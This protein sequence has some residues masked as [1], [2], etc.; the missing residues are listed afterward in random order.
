MITDQKIERHR[1]VVERQL[2]VVERQF[3]VVERQTQVEERRSGPF[4]LNL[5]AASVLVC[6]VISC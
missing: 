4:Q 2:Q 6:V 5:T 3:E 1:Q